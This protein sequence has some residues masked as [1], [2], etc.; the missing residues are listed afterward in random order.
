MKLVV[1][2]I[3]LS[4]VHQIRLDIE[5]Y[6][7]TQ[8]K[9]CGQ[10]L[11]KCGLLTYPQLEANFSVGITCNYHRH[12]IT[13]SLHL[14]RDLHM[15]CP[16]RFIYTDAHSMTHVIIRSKASLRAVYQTIRQP[17]SQVSFWLA[18]FLLIFLSSGCTCTQ[19]SDT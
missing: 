3:A 12:P 15:S 1:K 7:K 9:C 19:H 18:N 8:C 11:I 2:H 13:V 16:R 5:V 17:K 4:K 10:S 6:P 14:N